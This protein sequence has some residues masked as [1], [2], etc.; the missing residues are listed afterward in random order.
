MPDLNESMKLWKRGRSIKTVNEMVPLT[1]EHVDNL[2]ETIGTFLQE[3]RMERANRIRI[4]F[5]LEEAVLRWMD[6][7]GHEAVL[8]VEMTVNWGRPVITFT[9]PG[10]QYNPLVSSE[11]DLGDWAE[12]LYSG[13]SLSPVYNYRKGFNI[14]QLKLPNLNRNPA[15]ELM[16]SVM[17]GALIGVLGKAMLPETVRSVVLST[18][19]GPIEGVFLRILNAS[20]GPVIFLSVMTAICGIGM[21]PTIGKSGKDMV[22]RFLGLT[23]LST[24]SAAVISYFLLGMDL[25]PMSF[26]GSQFT[27]ILD[28]FL[29]MIPSDILTPFIEGNSPQLIALA[30]IIGNA[31]IVNSAQT[32]SLRTIV[33]QADS[34]GLTI[35]GWVSNLTPLFVATLLILGIWD[36]SVRIITGLWLPFLIY[37]LVSALGLYLRLMSVSRRYDV[38]V[39]LLAAKMKDSFRAA[40]VNA[41]VD[42][43]IGDSQ[44]LCEKR[45]GISKKLTDYA[46][47][48]GMVIYM[49]SGCVAC[50]IVTLYA[51]HVYNV[52]ITPVWFVIAVVLTAALIA[53]TPPVAGIGLLTYTA[54][55]AQLGIPRQALT[56][57]M[58]ADITLG[59]AV[60][61]LNLAMLQLELVNEAAKVDLLD[62]SILRKVR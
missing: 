23:L 27:S 44:I 16:L 61:A 10:E 41:S 21:L 55:F 3:V 36:G 60:S 51:A 43:A 33:E 56:M 42:A 40:F 52:T 8:H 17:I 12:N 50:M 18:V 14:L 48:L 25:S 4:R 47:P 31:L 45:F 62:R 58:V 22:W 11:N 20:S 57:A 30:I 34:I 32:V 39:K 26:D 19:L 6:H 24:A 35:A 49:P 53:A 28:F 37:F 1:P 59:F 5:S 29:G 9:M 7:F 46:F 2:S 13:L 54:I 38:P 15:L